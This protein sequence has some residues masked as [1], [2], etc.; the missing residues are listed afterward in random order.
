MRQPKVKIV[1]V[2]GPIDPGDPGKSR[3]Q[4]VR[5]DGKESR[6]Q[7]IDGDSP[8]FAAQ[9]LRLFRSNVRRARK[10]NRQLDKAS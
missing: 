8:N 10:E 4:V 5:R 6:Y 3:F 7:I 2:D 9:F 1:R